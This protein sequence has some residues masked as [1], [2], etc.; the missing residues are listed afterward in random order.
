MPTRASIEIG[1]Q[2]DEHGVN[3]PF[4]GR[5]DTRFGTPVEIEP[6]RTARAGSSSRRAR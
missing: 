4:A 5:H 1:P 2:F 6:R 3:A